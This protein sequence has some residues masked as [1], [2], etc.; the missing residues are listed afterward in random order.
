MKIFCGFTQA[1]IMKW[2]L[3]EASFNIRHQMLF[4]EDFAEFLFCYDAKYIVTHRSC[5]EIT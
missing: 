2:R 4:N 1:Q 3:T 5:S